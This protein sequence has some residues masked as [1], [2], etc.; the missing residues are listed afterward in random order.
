M[1]FSFFQSGRLLEM[2]AQLEH[3]SEELRHSEEMVES[4]KEANEEQSKKIENYCE[5]LK[6]VDILC[7]SY[8]G[9]SN[10]RAI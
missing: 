3:R 7:I 9:S 6:E 4:L 1:P 5:K 8:L 2:E 10:R